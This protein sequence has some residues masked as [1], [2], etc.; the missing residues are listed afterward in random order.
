[1]IDF[2]LS[3]LRILHTELQLESSWLDQLVIPTK[4]NLPSSPHP[5]QHLFANLL[6]LYNSGSEKIQSQSWFYLHFPN[7]RDAEQIWKYFL[8]IVFSLRMLGL[9]PRPILGIGHL[10]YWLLVFWGLCIVWILILC[11]IHRYQ[12]FPPILWVSSLPNWFFSCVEAFQVLWNPTCKLL[13]LILGWMDLCSAGPPVNF[14]HRTFLV[15]SP[16][17]HGSLVSL[18]STLS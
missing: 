13:I 1:M 12:R 11:Q 16:V 3:I 4:V 10:F 14:S 9:G 2:S 7:L 15:F 17:F 6:H 8:A 18:W 5:L